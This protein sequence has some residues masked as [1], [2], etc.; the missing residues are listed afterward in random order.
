MKTIV[1]K[2]GRESSLLRKHPWIFS[3]AIEHVNPKPKSGETVLITNASGQPMA[4]GAYSGKSQIRVRVWSF[5]AQEKINRDFF[6]KRIQKALDKR[7]ALNLQSQSNAF[8][9][10][11]AEA[12]GLPGLIVDRYADFLVV[13]ILSAGARFWKNDLIQILHEKFTP[14]GIFERSDSE[15]RRKEGLHSERGLLIGKEPPDQI[16][17]FENDL[18]FLV[19]VKNGH[20][21]GFYLDQRENRALLRNY[22]SDK[23]VLNCFAYTGGFG[24]AAAIGRAKRIVNVEAVGNL[25]EKITENVALNGFNPR[26][27]QN[28]QGD[29]FRVLRNFVLEDYRFDIIVLD[30]PKFA[31]RQSNLL[32]ASRGYKDINMQAI[33]L[34]KPGG[35]LFTFSCSGLMKADLFRKIVADAALDAGRQAQILGFL[36]Q[37]TDHPIMLNI[38]ESEYL[39]G[40]LIK[41]W[42]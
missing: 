18:R 38:P 3:G 7:R 20:K 25:V 41:V 21:T 22:A 2:K 10:I 11:N 31:D 40:L 5:D 37:A 16:E 29:V 15:A 9:L 35:L 34:L 28:I 13:Q 30:P 36:H 39:K 23:E 17:I 19:D 33:K 26:I 6:R 14:Q 12:D 1:L 27:F 24:L 42:D 32:K 4:V 8:R